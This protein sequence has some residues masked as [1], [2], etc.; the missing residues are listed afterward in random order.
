[1]PR[2]IAE[3]HEQIRVEARVRRPAWPRSGA[4]YLGPHLRLAARVISATWRARYWFSA[5]EPRPRPSIASEL[6]GLIAEDADH[7]GGTAE[8]QR[9]RGIL[10]EGT[11]AHRQL[12]IW[13]EAQAAGADDADAPRTVVDWLAKETVA[14]T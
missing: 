1:M 12:A 11:S 7:V 3:G 10:S 9:A 5:V 14:G 6:L 2:S 8:V 13:R 4:T